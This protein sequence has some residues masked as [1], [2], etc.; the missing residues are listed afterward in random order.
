M[1]YINVTIM[2]LWP[3]K[4]K[5]SLELKGMGERNNKSL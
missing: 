3:E 1:Y 5:S 4:D 2:L